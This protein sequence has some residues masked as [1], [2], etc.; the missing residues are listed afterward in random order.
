M[1]GNTEKDLLGAFKAMTWRQRMVIIPFLICALFL[2]L[3]GKIF[4]LTY[5]EFSV[6]FNLWI[7]GAVLLISSLLPLA[8]CCYVVASSCSW[9]NMFLTAFFLT[10]ALINLWAFVSMCQHYGKDKDVAFDRCV[11]DLTSIAKSWGMSYHM[12]NLLIFILFY[13]MLIAINIA[14]AHYVILLST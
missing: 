8:G 5:K 6:V 3:V 13:L 2:L 9:Q 12:V 1:Q 14:L 10:Y 11:L 4:H 7:Q